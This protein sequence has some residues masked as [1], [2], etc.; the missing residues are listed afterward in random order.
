MRTAGATLLLSGL[1]AVHSAQAAEAMEP[2]KLAASAT[3]TRDRF[4]VPHIEALT[5]DAV[6]FAFA[7]CQCEDYFWQL[8]DNFLLALGRY[9]EFHG[10]IGLN[11]DLLNRAFEIVPRSQKDYPGMPESTRRVCAAFVAGLNYFLEKNKATRPR[12]ITKFEPWHMVALQRQLTLELTYRYT[13]LSHDFAPRANRQ[14]WAGVG[15]NAYALAPSKTRDGHAILVINPHQPWFGF[16]QFTEAHLKSGEG[17]EFSGGAFFGLPFPFLGFNA[18]CGWAATTNEPDIADAWRE[19]F[20]DPNNPLNYRYGNGY[21]TASEWKDTIAIRTPSGGLER[22]AHT[23]RKTH[24]GPIVEK[25]TDTVYLSAM[26]ARLYESNLIGQGAE[27]MRVRSFEDFYRGIGKLNFQYMNLVFADNKGNIFYIWGGIVPRRDPRFRWNEPVDGS[28]P[29]TEWHGYHSI[30]ELPQ[31]LN[32]PT[33][34]VQNCNSSPFTTTDEGSPFP[35]DF[36][37]YMVEDQYDDKRRAK[38]ARMML[39]DM[40]QATFEQ[41]QSALFDTKVFWAYNELPEY[42]RDLERLRARNSKLAAAA[43]PYLRHLLDWDANVTADTTAATLCL[44]WYEEL[45]GFGYPNET[46]K[47]RFVENPDLRFAALVDAANKLKSNYGTWKVKWG[48]IHRIQRHAD[49]ADFIKIPFDDAQP[50]LPSWGAPSPPGVLFTQMYTP[51]INIPLVKKQ[52]KRYGVV[53]MTYVGCIE[54]GPKVR[55]ATLT[56]F[57]QSGDPKS[58]HFFDQAPLLSARKLK[59]ATLDWTQIRADAE[60]VYHPGEPPTGKAP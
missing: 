35:G 33:G 59:P 39:R 2:A 43:E 15:S 37:R 22:R 7:Y 28:D 44:Q 41:M 52:L 20:D 57:G 8:E 9:A 55:A 10:S 21:R 56:Q 48:D 31:V 23:F 49:V 54:F 32:P 17:W 24:H 53:G 19:T 4:G 26:I 40:K 38:R 13:R 29:R 34:Y 27:M 51:T 18:D 58:P 30:E 50:S 46:L 1:C 6:I 45:Y 5:D 25:V 36:P 42:A 14:I 11:S 12:G 60:R 16:G 47:P 3:V